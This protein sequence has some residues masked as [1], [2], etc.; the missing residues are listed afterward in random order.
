[1]FYN[2]TLSRQEIEKALEIYD[3]LMIRG[4]LKKWY[5]W[6]HID[7]LISTNSSGRAGSGDDTSWLYRYW[8]LTYENKQYIARAMMT[9]LITRV[10]F[11][12]NFRLA[13]I[14][15][16]RTGAK[17]PVETAKKC[18]EII[19]AITDSA[20]T[21]L[22]ILH[23][24][25][26]KYFYCFTFVRTDTVVTTDT[27]RYCIQYMYSEAKERHFTFMLQLYVRSLE[28]FRLYFDL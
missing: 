9:L 4:F 6:H 1:M 28:I 15:L 12:V 14:P 3:F 19:P 2:F 26:K 24:V 25:P 11:T 7:C 8:R 23:V 22:R 17:S 5:T 16:L 18:M 13:D 20:L 10:C 21:E 27:L